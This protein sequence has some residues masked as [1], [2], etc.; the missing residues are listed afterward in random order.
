MLRQAW[1]TPLVVLA[2]FPCL[3]AR[4]LNGFLTPVFV[5]GQKGPFVPV[6]TTADIDFGE[7]I[8]GEI[9]LKDIGRY[10]LLGKQT[11]GR[12]QVELLGEDGAKA[13]EAQGRMEDNLLELEL[14]LS[15]SGELWYR[16]RLS[17][18]ADVEWRASEPM[19][20][21]REPR[22]KAG[23]KWYEAGFDDSEW[24][25]IDLPDDGTFGEK[26]RHARYYRSYFSLSKPQEAVSVSLT[27][28]ASKAEE[29]SQESESFDAV[30]ASDDGIAIYINGRLLGRWI[31]DNDG[32]VNDPLQRCGY[33]AVVPPVSIPPAFVKPG[34]NLLAVRVLNVHCCYSYFN[35]LVTRVR[36]RLVSPAGE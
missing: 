14:N 10:R 16:G 12:L 1:L 23:L 29:T 32:C 18:E 27:G 26:K 15:K 3:R 35:L 5:Q 28:S 25:L 36:T 8:R 11:D 19:K 22:N 24:E 4:S 7:R 33:N 30:F 9:H 21:G 13:G 20:S 2:C 17:L 6:S 31:G 34:K